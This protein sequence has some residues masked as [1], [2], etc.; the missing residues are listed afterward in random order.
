MPWIK[1]GY[2]SYLNSFLNSLRNHVGC[3]LPASP[4]TTINTIVKRA[5]TLHDYNFYEHAL[6][7]SD[8]RNANKYDPNTEHYRDNT[9]SEE[10][11]ENLIE[12][13]ER[14]KIYLVPKHAGRNK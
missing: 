7:V 8:L 5:F 14:L 9:L 3:N 1:N 12:E 4:N 6:V 10:D 13:L 11:L 2:K